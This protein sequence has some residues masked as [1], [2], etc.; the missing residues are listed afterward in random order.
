LEGN[1]MKTLMTM[2]HFMMLLASSAFWLNAANASLLPC[3][4]GGANSA[5]GDPVVSTTVITCG[6]LIFS[7]F[8][9]TNA[10]GG[11]PG[12]VDILAGVAYDSLTGDTYLSF[13]PNLQANQDEQ[14]LFEATG[15]ISD[16]ALSLGGDNASITERACLNPISTS[17]ALAFL[18]TDPTGTIGVQP[19]GQITVASG[20][21]GQ[22]VFSA[23]FTQSSP[24][25][26]F[27][28]VSTGANGQL[29]EF[30]Q[31]FEPGSGTPEPVSMALLGSGLLSLGLLLRRSRKGAPATC[32]LL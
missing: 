4:I 16:M 9:V 14:F 13:N 24:I 7:S 12:L 6:S 10:T 18:C 5:A 20:A 26:V 11:A 22:P 15:G 8:D 3:T 19:L 1:A 32:I 23:P 27:T 25:Y 2:E 17:G 28:D 31:S 29:G 30:T 21:P